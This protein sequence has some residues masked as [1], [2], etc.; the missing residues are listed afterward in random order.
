MINRTVK[1]KK[2][3]EININKIKSKKELSR[4]DNFLNEKNNL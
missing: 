2:F 3:I 1:N 4:L